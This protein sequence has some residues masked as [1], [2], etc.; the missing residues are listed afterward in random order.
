MAHAIPIGDRHSD[1]ALME[2][3][4]R[5]WQTKQKSIAVLEKWLLK[6]ADIEIKMGLKS[7]L[8]DERRQIHILDDEIKRFG[9]LASTAAREN[10]LD[11]PFAIVLSQPNDA[12][13][14][15]AF[16]RGIKVFSVDRCGHLIP[17]VESRLARVLEQMA[18]DDE[19][20][21]RWA[22]IRLARTQ[23]IEEQRQ[24]SVLQ[25]RVLDALETAW[26]RPWTQL[27]RRRFA[28]PPAWR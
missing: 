20:H 8:T 18:R 28:A 22:D 12:L 24:R 6:T 21:V 16:H 19:R 14:L 4:V 13:R 15:T 17:L 9:G 5:L 27:A 23:G 3:L 1:V 25:R 11:R 7:Q 26:T 2:V 10:A